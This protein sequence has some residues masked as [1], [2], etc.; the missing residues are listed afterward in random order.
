MAYLEL[1]PAIAALRARPEEF[2]FSN[3][4]LHHLGSRHRFRFISEDSVEI[5]APTA[6]ALY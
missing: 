5:H 4:T 2:E 3:D 1:S 6:A